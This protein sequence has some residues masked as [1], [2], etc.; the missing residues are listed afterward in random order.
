MRRTQAYIT[1][2]DE[3]ERYAKTLP[4]FLELEAEIT[5]LI[6]DYGACLEGAYRVAYY[7]SLETEG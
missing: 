1:I 3:V 4:R 6:R 7:R 5:R 2:R